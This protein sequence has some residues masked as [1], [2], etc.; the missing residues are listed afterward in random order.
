MILSFRSTYLL[1]LLLFRTTFGSPRSG[2]VTAM[3]GCNV[4]IKFIIKCILKQN[5]LTAMLLT[6]SYGIIF[7]GFL[8]MIAEH[9]IDRVL[10]FATMKFTYM[11]SCWLT[12]ITMTTVGYGDINPKTE[13]GKFIVIFI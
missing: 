8:I 9:P 11:N 1:G 5:P 12:I 4:N 3:F 10:N 6:F 13:I 7:F 2:R